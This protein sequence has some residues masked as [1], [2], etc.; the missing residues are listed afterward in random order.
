MTL[1]WGIPVD[2]GGEF[3]VFTDWAY[4]SEVNF[5]LYDSI[6]FTGKSL[7]EGGLR[8]G[9]NWGYGKYDVAVYRPQHHRRSA[10][11][12]RHRLQQ[13]DR[14]SSTSRALFGAEFKA[15]F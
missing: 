6:E 12:R 3:Y 4:R 13:P 9:Y 8:L 7:L 10:G 1:R 2:N 14:A 5:F 15:S 11:G